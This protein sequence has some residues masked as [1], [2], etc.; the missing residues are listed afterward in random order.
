MCLNK[1]FISTEGPGQP[2]IYVMHYILENFW[3]YDRFAN[4]KKRQFYQ[5]EIQFLRFV[6]LAKE[7]RI[8]G[9]KIEAVKIRSELKSARDI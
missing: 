6:V 5:D 9:K 8:E 4:L 7:I 1:L 3:K 2:H